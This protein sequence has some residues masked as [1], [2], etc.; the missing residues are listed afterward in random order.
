MVSNIAFDN[1]PVS[2]MGV[3][4]E[5]PSFLVIAKIRIIAKILYIHTA[6]SEL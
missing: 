2:N 5:R 6:R 3:L 4:N 1:K